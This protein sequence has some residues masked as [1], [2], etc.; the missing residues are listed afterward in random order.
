[1]K[2]FETSIMID[3]SAEKVWNI[4]TDAS[5]YTEWD[6][7]MIS[8]DGTVAKGEKLTIKAK[9]SPDRAFTPTVTVFEPNRHMVWG[10]G[11]P[12][13]LFKGERTF[14][15]EPI[16]SNQTRFTM[17]EVFSG[18]M[19]ALIGGTI[20]DMNPIFETFAKNLKA[21]AEA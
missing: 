1:M 2:A 12:L 21:R 3:A 9:V 14:T 16:G 20:P 13:G 7:G 11:M 18:P 15:L 19:M 6:E 4:L 17:K 5:K 10:S 8:L